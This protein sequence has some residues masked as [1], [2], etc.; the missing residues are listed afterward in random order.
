MY[1]LNK[2][3]SGEL[4]RNVSKQV[5]TFVFMYLSSYIYVCKQWVFM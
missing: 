1:V 5:S 3:L 2:Y 4:C